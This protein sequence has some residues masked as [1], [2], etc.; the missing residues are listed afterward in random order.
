MITF[1]EFLAWWRAGRGVTANA[2]LVKG[3]LSALNGGKMFDEG[4]LVVNAN[5][6]DSK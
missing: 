3:Y 6:G 2:K 4:A 5:I 1:E